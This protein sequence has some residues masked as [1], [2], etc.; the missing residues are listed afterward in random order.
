MVTVAAD[1][2]ARFTSVETEAER[3]P[4]PL[5][6][7]DRS[8]QARPRPGRGG[9]LGE[10]F[11][12]DG[13][14][15]AVQH[16]APRER[17]EVGRRTRG[18]MRHEIECHPGVHQPGACEARLEVEERQGV[19]KAEEWPAEA[20]GD[21]P[22]RA[23]DAQ[24]A[25]GAGGLEAEPLAGEE[26]EAAVG[27]EEEQPAAATRIETDQPTQAC[28]RELQTHG[29]R[30]GGDAGRFRR[31]IVAI[32]AQEQCRQRRDA[33]FEEAPP[34]PAGPAEGD[35]ELELYRVD[36]RGRCRERADERSRIV[37]VA[38]GEQLQ[39]ILAVTRGVA[40]ADGGAD[41]ACPARRHQGGDGGR[42]KRR[43]DGRRR[44]HEE[45]I[46][47]RRA[48]ETQVEDWLD[49][50]P[51]VHGE[52]R[53]APVSREHG[54]DHRGE[55]LEE[56][57]RAAVRLPDAVQIDVVA[58]RV[59]VDERRRPGE[60]GELGGER[61]GVQ[62]V[63]AQVAASPWPPSRVATPTVRG[64]EHERSLA[65]EDGETPGRRHAPLVAFRRTRVYTRVMRPALLAVLVTLASCAPVP[66]TSGPARPHVYL[67]V[68][69]GLDPRFATPALMPR[70]FA[71]L[72]REPGRS[73][74]FPTARAV[75]P[76]RTNPNHVTLLTGVYAEAH[77]ITGNAYWRRTPGARPERL[78]AAALI[79]VE[80][81]FTVAGG[82][83][84]AL[85]TL[86]A[87]GKPK[88]AR[89]F[90]TVPGRQR[91]PDVLWSA[92][93]LPF[94]R[95][96]PSG[97]AADADTVEAAL[98]AAAEREPDLS[99][100]NLSDVDRAG[101]AAGPES[102]AYREAIAAADTALAR[103][104]DDLQARGR[105]TRS[106]V[107]I[108]ADHG[109]TS[110][111][112]TPERPQPTISLT[113]RV[114]RGGV[115][116]VADGGVEHVYADGPPTEGVAGQS[117]SHAAE[118][119]ATIPGVAEIV[120][121]LPGLGVP[122]LDR[123]HP[124][125]HLDHPRAGDLLLVAEPGYQ[126]VDP[127]DPVDASLRGNHGGPETLAVP[128][129]VTG[130]WPGLAAAPVGTPPPELVDVAPTMAAILELRRPRR[131]DGAP[132]A[133]EDAGRPI[134]AV[135]RSSAGDWESGRPPRARTE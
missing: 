37:A 109:M 71:L 103:L 77:G 72:A 22:I 32:R 28:G 121:R 44:P 113:A 135:L 87:F 7:A 80:T 59:G 99:F 60:R 92:A 95:R 107:L 47:A 50:V 45:R 100:L 120:S 123:T 76:A 94:W 1:E 132:V 13:V 124:G 38:R 34:P 11:S 24:P 88:L 116:L 41:A 10:A 83:A 105:W 57:R 55:A 27:G 114:E 18:V 93:E 33:G 73:S 48:A 117:L 14:S 56:P 40:C 112:P 131:L 79:E 2:P 53:R 133:P 134:S 111:A 36:R 61:R 75:M 29:R 125:W 26:R 130:G 52:E 104:V 23:T 106:V 74:F 118:I 39:E 51:A 89:L 20:D 129:A 16:D 84:P 127:W 110:V 9:I 35:A 101:H 3:D 81:L 21:T 108:T 62:V 42:G 68:V 4:R 66:P 30:G 102:A 5:V 12:H 90:A 25:R 64:H 49:D 63:H 54:L 46:L 69:D 128:L 6:D 85:R 65:R 119:A 8:P 98:E 31:R 19:R 126:F 43:R 91:G 82:S 67:I 58:V 15:R 17:A 78:E 70:L 97:Y 115:T 96:E 122:M 86:G